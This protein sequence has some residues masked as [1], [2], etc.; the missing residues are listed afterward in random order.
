M[1]KWVAKHFRLVFENDLYSF[2]LYD[3]IKYIPGHQ[4]KI[5]KIY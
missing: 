2:N 5:I 4:D 3:K 1:L